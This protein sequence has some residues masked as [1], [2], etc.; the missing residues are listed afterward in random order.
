MPKH[1]CWWIKE[2]MSE[3]ISGFNSF[4]LKEFRKPEGRKT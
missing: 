1:A 4:K 2:H 3:E